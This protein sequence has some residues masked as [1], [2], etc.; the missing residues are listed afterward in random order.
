MSIEERIIDVMQKNIQN[1]PQINADS[2]LQEDLHLD[3]FDI[4]MVITAL[5][6][7]FNIEIKETDFADLVTVKDIAERIKHASV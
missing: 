6:D 7:E 4:L 2:R 5:E 1:S 3:S